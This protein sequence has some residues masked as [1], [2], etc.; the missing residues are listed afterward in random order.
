MFSL[1]ISTV[2]AFVPLLVAVSVDLEGAGVTDASAIQAQL[3]GVLAAGN[4]RLKQAEEEHEKVL[5]KIRKD[6]ADDFTNRASDLGAAV[7]QYKTDLEAAQKKLQTEMDETQKGLDKIG[8]DLD[9]STKARIGAK[10]GVAQRHLRHS[11]RTET[12]AMESANR[13]AEEPLDH[14]ADSLM[15]MWVGD[16]SKP[17]NE[18]KEKLHNIA[19]EPPFDPKAASQMSDD[20]DAALLDVLNS[21]GMGGA[22]ST[23]TTTKATTTTTTTT[24]VPKMSAAQLESKITAADKQLTAETKAALKKLNDAIAK[25]DKDVD[26]NNVKVKKTLKDAEKKADDFVKQ[27][28]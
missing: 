21:H 24:T 16:L 2:A 4:A 23:T 17:L 7:A 11:T 5:T 19:D 22:S 20:D 13:R 12:S 26:S 15:S 25:A 10:I 14:E 6:A 1:R 28:L 9:I 3:S 18:A 8:A 27:Q